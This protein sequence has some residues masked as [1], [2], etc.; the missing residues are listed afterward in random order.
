MNACRK[1]AAVNWFIEAIPPLRSTFVP[2]SSLW[3]AVYVHCVFTRDLFKRPLRHHSPDKTR[4]NRRIWWKSRVVSRAFSTGQQNRFHNYFFN[5]NYVFVVS[6]FSH[7]NVS[8]CVCLNQ[9]IVKQYE[10]IWNI[11]TTK[12]LP[13]AY[14]NGRVQ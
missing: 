10:T 7:H 11:I 5:I 3:L 8:F 4:A 2:S 12:A 9:A 1:R 6:I 13:A 14:L